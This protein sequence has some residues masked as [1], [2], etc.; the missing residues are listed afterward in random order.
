MNKTAFSS[1]LVATL[2][3]EIR[4][5]L[6]VNFVVSND[7]KSKIFHDIFRRF[8]QFDP[9]LLEVEIS[10]APV[11]GA[12]IHHYHRPHLEA[13]LQGPAVATV[14]HDPRDVDPWF[15]NGKFV[16]AY[17][18][19]EKIICLNSLQAADLAKEGLHDTVVIPH[20]YDSGIFSKARKSHAAERKLTI[21]IISKRYDRR[22]KGDAYVHEM[23]ERLSPDRIRFMLVG[24]GRTLDAARMRDMGFEATVFEYLPYRLF[25]DLYRNMDFLLVASVNEGGP[26]NLPE[27]LGSSTPVL[28]T[29]V[30]MVPDL[31]R[32][33]ENGV[34]LSGNI[35][36]DIARL[37]AVF[38]NRDGLADRLM[39]GA[40]E[41][42][43]AICWEEV[44]ARHIQ[45]YADVVMARKS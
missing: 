22:V 36:D 42:E 3:A 8:L 24:A 7:L 39:Q 1:D 40:H 6:R 38:E 43:T 31:V 29:P 18:Q 12:D 35:R 33:G 16:A 30:G 27:A 32:D 25:G 20:G 11:A 13:E 15:D 44:I 26:A 5:P 23:L 28:C 4:L 37:E 14:H 41:M 17:R 10:E 19:T 21:G 9:T 45:L 2:P 34:I